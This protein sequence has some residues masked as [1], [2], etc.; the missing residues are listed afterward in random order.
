MN[1]IKTPALLGLGLLGLGLLLSACDRKLPEPSTPPSPSST[2]APAAATTP[3]PAAD[4][5]LPEQLPAL[6]SGVLPCADCEGIRYDLDLRPDKVFFLRMTYLGKAP[7]NIFDDIGEWG[8]SDADVLT[9]HGGRESREMFSVKDAQTLRKLD[10]EGKEIESQLNYTITR[11]STYSPIEPRLNLRGAYRYMADAGIFEECLTGLK[12]AVAQESDNAA[13]EAA[14]AKARKDPGQPVLVNVE[15]R[16]VRRKGMEGDQ[17]R[18]TL[19]VE[20]TGEF[21]P[22][23]SCGARGVTHDLEGTRWVLVRL[24]NEPVTVTDNQREPYFALESS[25]HRISG[26][27]GCNRLVGGYELDGDK[28]TFTQ[29]ALTRMACLTPTPEGQFA[30]ALEAAR[31]WKITGAHLELSDV[32][33]TV[34]ARFESRNL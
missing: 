15:G 29:L 33:G 32:N 13:L 12:L 11:Q 7:D 22:N 16:I 26:H 4:A 8:I 17:L 1:P 14:Y 25:E 18:D 9:L 23:E 21:H 27:G 30:K 20:K 24:G 3:P 6:Y 28:I 34:V 10:M 19:I 2:T 5:S 31:T